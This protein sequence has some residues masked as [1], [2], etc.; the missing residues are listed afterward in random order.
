MAALLAALL[1]PGSA[2]ASASA[3]N[4]VAPTVGGGANPAAK[5]G[6]FVTR[7]GSQLKLGGKPFRFSGANIEWLGLIGYGPLNFEPSQNERFPTHYEIDDALATAH[8][9]G[10][11]VVRAQTLGDTVGCP[12]CLEPRAGE[13][14]PAAFAV[15]DYA[16]ARAKYYGIRLIMEFEGDSRAQ[17]VA[18]TDVYSRWGGGGNFYTDPKVIRTFEGHIAAILNRVNTYTGVAYKNDPSI[19]GWMDCNFCGDTDAANT[20]KWIQAI[21]SYVKSIDHQ[22]LFISN[23][24]I[25]DEQLLAASSV[26]A[27]A[28]EI[29]PHW[30]P[31]A[32]MTTEQMNQ[33][34]H[35]A[36]AE[37]VAAGKVWFMSEYGWDKTDLATPADLQ[38]FL[39][40]VEKDPN[41]SGDLFW[42]L[43]SHT[44]GHGW[45]PIPAN[46]LCQPGTNDSTPPPGP[47]P[48]DGSG[49]YSNEDGNWWALYY[50][51]IPTMSHTQ[52]DMAA[53]AQILR[54]HAYQMRGFHNT[55]KHDTP[56]APT[57][58]STDGGRVYWQGSAGAASYSIQRSTAPQGHWTTVCDHC[59]TDLSDGWPETTNGGWYRVIPYNLDG[60]PGPTSAPFPG[61]RR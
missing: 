13:F 31:Y 9:M 4:H 48:A 24:S 16:I 30:A 42:A 15:M 60:K 59:V 8:E 26:D 7:S 39:T 34:A 40:G 5:N 43:E 20:N 21:G 45:Q 33:L 22:H 2:A 27:Y 50:T 53:R 12:N 44:N 49:C 6:D 38:N 17:H 56:P 18:D 19:L 36:A 35:T 61:G 1:L 58:T 29:Y 46:E 52:A 32:G 37:A 25:P 14:N 28:L 3:A 47:G 57:I 11:T 10:A 23:G 41:I 51:G 55:P 54:T